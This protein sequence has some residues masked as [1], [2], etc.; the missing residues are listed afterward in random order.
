MVSQPWITA[1]STSAFEEFRAMISL[2]YYSLYFYFLL[3][4]QNILLLLA[5]LV[6]KKKE[7]NSR[8]H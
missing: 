5:S 2:N 4:F 6:I 7:I 3:D 8:S 1:I